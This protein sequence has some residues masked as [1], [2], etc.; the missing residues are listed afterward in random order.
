[1]SGARV[2]PFPAEHLEFASNDGQSGVLFDYAFAVLTN[3]GICGNFPDVDFIETFVCGG[4]FP[5]G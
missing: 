1:M 5:L 4:N 2:R 3:H